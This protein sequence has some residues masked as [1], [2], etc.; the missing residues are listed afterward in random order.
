MALITKPPAW[1]YCTTNLSGT[2]SNGSGNGTAVIAGTNNADGSNT[3]ILTAVSHDVELIVINVAGLAI[4]G[5]NGS[6]LLD[7]LVDPA[8]GTSWSS[9]PL[10]SDLIVGCSVGNSSTAGYAYTYFFPLWV[11]SGSSLG[12][13]IRSSHTGSLTS[14]VIL[15]LYGGNSNP[16]SW[17]CGQN[18]ESIGIN[19]ASST[20]TSHTPGNTGAYSTWT[21]FGSTTTNVSGAVQYAV[22]GTSTTTTANGAGYHMEFGVASTRIGPNVLRMTN[23]SESGWQLPTGPIFCSLPSGTQLQVRGTCSGTAQALDV[24]AYVVS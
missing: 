12:A 21:N 10:I 22:H 7:L 16:S 4:A 3:S 23:T 8:G 15:N 9:T 20:G 17:W 11:K 2:P 5:G 14:R 18:V 24:A 13:R 6:A 1:A 19:A